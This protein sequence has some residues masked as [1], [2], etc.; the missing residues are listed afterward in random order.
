MAVEGVIF[1]FN[2]TLFW[3]THLHNEA[4]DTYL[5]RHGFSWSDEEK[6]VRIHGKTNQDI[7][8]GIYQ[9]NISEDELR[10]MIMEK[11]TI[12]QTLCKQQQMEL[13]PGVVALLSFLKDSGVPY[14][15]ATASGK[16][17]VDFYFEQ[18]HLERWFRYGSIV[19]N[20]GSFRGKPNPDIFLLA[21]DRLGL[22][23]AATAVFEDSISGIQAAENAGA[24][25]IIIVNSNNEDYSGWPYEVVTDFNGVERRLFPQLG[26]SF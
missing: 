21:A 24:G 18:L 1:D 20:D 11:E 23:P 25:K 8:Q 13:A 12:Y 4:W 9:R 22:K 6:N 16:E 19:Y 10:Q 17:N 2:G 15:I 7:F 14:T 26:G 3:D 5:E